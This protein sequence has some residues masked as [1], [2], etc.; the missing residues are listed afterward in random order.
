MGESPQPL[1]QLDVP[2]PARTI[3]HRHPCTPAARATR[4]PN[5]HERQPLAW[6]RASPFFLQAG[7]SARRC[8]EKAPP[9]LVFS[10]ARLR[11]VE[12]RLRGSKC[13]VAYSRS[14]STFK[15]LRWSVTGAPALAR[16]EKSK[17]SV[18]A[19]IPTFLLKCPRLKA[20]K[21]DDVST[22]S[23]RHV[24]STRAWYHQTKNLRTPG[25]AWTRPVGQFC[26]SAKHRAQTRRSLHVPSRCDCGV[27]TT[28]SPCWPQEPI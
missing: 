4:T 3:P 7:P 6:Q 2:W 1:S 13:L 15:A 9:R 10:A 22:N 28:S 19:R 26:S 27:G 17:P 18:L 23:G 21:Q 5:V 16:V 8:P 20:T 24:R 12:D 14:A 11:Q 25:R